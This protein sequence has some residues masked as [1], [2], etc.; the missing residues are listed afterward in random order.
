MHTS[1]NSHSSTHPHTLTP[2]PRAVFSWNTESHHCYT[3][4]NP[5][6]APEANPRVTSGC[7]TGVVVGCG[8]GPSPSPP[9]PPGPGPAPPPPSPKPKYDGVIRDDT[10]GSRV[11]YMIPPYLSVSHST[12]RSRHAHAGGRIEALDSSVG[13]QFITHSSSPIK[14]VSLTYT[15]AHPHTP[16]GCH[17]EHHFHTECTQYQL[18]SLSCIILYACVFT[19]TSHA[20]TSSPLRPPCIP[21]H[22]GRPQQN[23]ASTL[24]QLPDGSLVAAWFSG[25]KEEAS[26]CAI[27]F[28]KLPAGSS[29]W[30]SAATL[31]KRDGYSNQNPVLFYDNTTGVLHL[32][33][34]QAPAESGESKSEIWHLSS[35]NMGAN[36]TTPEPYATSIPLL[37]TPTWFNLE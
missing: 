2:L 19:L 14:H 5:V 36:W 26:G 32:F 9:S 27:V 17:D 8:A 11:A 30:S 18:A 22:H 33:H 31:S 24:E 28:S 20:H 21:H 29:T 23:H 25:M 1:I 13:L 12:S 34:S 6:W 3:N 4:T 35:S 16:I 7:K 15:R 10:D 37:P